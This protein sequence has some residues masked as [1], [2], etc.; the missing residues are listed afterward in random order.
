MP[1]TA[2]SAFDK[3]GDYYG[4]KVVKI[5][6]DSK[7]WAVDMGK[8]AKAINKNTICVYISLYPCIKF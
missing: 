3:A 4:I 8:L 7:T 1:V 2:H 5:P 6:V